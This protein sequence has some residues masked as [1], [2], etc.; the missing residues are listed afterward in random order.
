MRH[1]LWITLITATGKDNRAAA[2]FDWL[3]APPNGIEPDN[4]TVLALNEI[5]RC[6]LVENWHIVCFQLFHQ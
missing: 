1:H 5:A 2:K 4:G 6:G 3:V